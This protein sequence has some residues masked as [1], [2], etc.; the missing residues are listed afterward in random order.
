[1][2]ENETSEIKGKVSI[3]Q[4]PFRHYKNIPV[5]VR[6]SNNANISVDHLKPLLGDLVVKDSG[7]IRINN[8]RQTHA[9]CYFDRFK[10]PHFI[11]GQIPYKVNTDPE[12]SADTGQNTFWSVELPIEQKEDGFLIRPSEQFKQSSVI[13]REIEMAK[14]FYKIPT[15]SPQATQEEEAAYYNIFNKAI[16]GDGDYSRYDLRDRTVL[17][18]D[19]ETTKDVDDAIEIEKMDRDIYRIGVHIADVAEFI[20]AGSERDQDAYERTTS[21][22]LADTVVHMLPGCLSEE[23]CSLNPDTERLALSVFVT[24]KINEDAS[25]TF[26]AIDFMESVIESKAKLTYRYVEKVMGDT[27]P[28]AEDN[29]IDTALCHAKN[30]YERIKGGCFHNSIEYDNI[31][32]KYFEDANGR[33]ERRQERKGR[34]DQL[35]E[36]FMLLTNWIV[37]IKTGDVIVSTSDKP[38]GLGMYRIQTPPL[39]N[40]VKEFMS[41]LRKNGLIDDG[42]TYDALFEEAKM[43]CSKPIPSPLQ[44][45]PSDEEKNARLNAEI[46]R[47]LYSRI[48]GLDKPETRLKLNVLS[49][50]GFIPGRL[51]KKSI[52]RSDIHKSFHHS[53]GISRYAWF[54]SPIRR[55]T[56]IVNHRI[57][58]KNLGRQD[59][60]NDGPNPAQITQRLNNAK[61]AENG[62]KNRMLMYFLVN[63]HRLNK[64]MELSVML[65]SFRWRVDGKFQI[66]GIWQDQFP[67]TFVIR[68]T[69]NVEIDS[70]GTLCN[71]IDNQNISIGDIVL[72]K[73]I[74]PDQDISPETGC[75]FIDTHKQ[76]KISW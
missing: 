72:V 73:I 27:V 69:P 63:R 37:G 30:I 25:L 38:C 67:L 55:Y 43:N 10:T 56:D 47:L 31:E 36:N 7:G 40:E 34:A 3:Y 35:I 33:I 59:M 28:P 22:Y 39:S 24:V 6:W 16:S 20:K 41:K 62:F 21:H 70:Y 13:Q 74:N 23:L 50:F 8:R 57:I 52:I 17:T 4:N 42:L 29:D 66:Q 75:I 58:K 15:D 65:S 53:I 51:E 44:Y 2:Q 32:T 1:M 61:F 76:F 71:I 19:S 45:S 49:Q 5:R 18:I 54:T 68:E 14:Y 11:Y 46:F 48:R 12:I 26:K 9:V 60:G 64:Q